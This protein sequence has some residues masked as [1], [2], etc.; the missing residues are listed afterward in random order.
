MLYSNFRALR[1]RACMV[2]GDIQFISLSQSW[3]LVR[4]FPGPLQPGT[5][6]SSVRQLQLP[7]PGPMGPSPRPS[8]TAILPVETGSHLHA[9][10]QIHV[11]SSVGLRLFERAHSNRRSPANEGC[12][13][14]HRTGRITGESSRWNLVC[15]EIH[16][17]SSVG[18]PL[19]EYAS[20]STRLQ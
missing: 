19:F 7:G 16:I 12:C 20:S 5:S 18:L 15:W 6:S 17:P 10:W 11:P 8:E 9:C 2:L 14:I 13:S 4:G 1:S 3:S